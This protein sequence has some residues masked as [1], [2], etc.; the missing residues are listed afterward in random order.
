MYDDQGI[1]ACGHH[2]REKGIKFGLATSCLSNQQATILACAKEAMEIRVDDVV[3]FGNRELSS[4]Q[5]TWWFDFTAIRCGLE[6]DEPCEYNS[7]D[8]VELK[9]MN[10]IGK[11][12]RLTK[13]NDGGRPAWYF[14]VIDKEKW[15]QMNE[16]MSLQDGNI[17]NVVIKYGKI[18]FSGF[19]ED[20]PQDLVDRVN[21][22]IITK[23]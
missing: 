9:W 14:V 22:I 2:I 21:D 8:E 10:I 4:G 18:L 12:I 15:V 19:G 17:Y 6:P 3:F 13:G 16:E 20:P 11:S 5:M 23:Y 7:H 1:L